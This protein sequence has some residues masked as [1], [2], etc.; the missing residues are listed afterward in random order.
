MNIAH[1]RRSSAG[2]GPQCGGHRLIACGSGRRSC[3]CPAEGGRRARDIR[4]PREH[5]GL[6]HAWPTCSRLRRSDRVRR[7]RAA[8]GHSLRT[9]DHGADGDRLDQFAN[10]SRRHPR[11]PGD[12]SNDGHRRR[13]VPQRSRRA[14]LVWIHGRCARNWAAEQIEDASVAIALN[15]MRQFF[16]RAWRPLRARFARKPPRD[17]RRFKQFFGAPLLFDQP[18]TC[19]EFDAAALDLPVRS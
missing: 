1:G 11:D 9:D 8:S 15:V 18:R 4:E 16:G 12:A 3:N 13:G 19:I 6:R 5:L 14:C 17:R 10:G 7:F 2:E